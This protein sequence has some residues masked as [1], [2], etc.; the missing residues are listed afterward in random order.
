MDGRGPLSE[1]PA[2]Q[3]LQAYFDQ[4]GASINIAKM[5]EADSERFKTFRYEL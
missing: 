5:F 3:K 2:Y 1:D 4:N